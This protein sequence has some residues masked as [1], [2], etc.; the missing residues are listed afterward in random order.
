M[1][2]SSFNKDW[3]FI[4]CNGVPLYDR[5]SKRYVKKFQTGSVVT[6]NNVICGGDHSHFWNVGKIGKNMVYIQSTRNVNFKL[7]VSKE[8]INS[9]VK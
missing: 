3:R 8:L 1:Y 4:M 5:M 7:N 6:V 2:R 9:V